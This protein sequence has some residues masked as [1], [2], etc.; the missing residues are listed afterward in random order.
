[1]QRPHYI[2]QQ[3]RDSMN[4]KEQDLIVLLRDKKRTKEQIKR[5][6]YIYSDRTYQ[7]IIKKVSK[8]IRTPFCHDNDL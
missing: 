5:K 8:K 6:L 1:M 2:T 4:R 3:V 7:R